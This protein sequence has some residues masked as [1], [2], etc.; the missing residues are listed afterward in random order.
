MDNFRKLENKFFKEIEFHIK[1]AYPKING[2]LVPST[3]KEDTELS[4]D[5]KINDK[6]FSIR[7]RKHKY[8][9]Y[10][11]LTIRAKSKNNGRTEIDKITDGLAQVYFYAYMNKEENFLVKV[12][13]VD[14]VSIR[15]LTQKN[16]FKK[17]KNNDGTEFNTYLFSDIKKENGAVYKYD[18]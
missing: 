12:R 5:A 1:K 16:K 9:K 4:F 2:N 15:K 18:K 8:L 17:R 11:D 14:V 3:D 13:I 6:Q 10:P 7:I